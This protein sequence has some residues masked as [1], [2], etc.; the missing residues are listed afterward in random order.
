MA[1]PDKVAI[2]EEIQQKLDGSDAAVLTEYRGLTVGELAELRSALRPA[3]T[4]YKV[5][6]N[7]LARR[8][9]EASGHEELLDLL[10]GPVAFAFVQGDAAVAAK[11]IDDFAGD[12]DALIVKGGLLGDTFLAAV[13]VKALAKLEPRDVILAKIAGAFQA[14]MTKAAGLFSAIPRQM[15]QLTQALVDKRVAEGEEPETDT[16]TEKNDD[17]TESTED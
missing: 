1:R 8:A 7:S 13:D 5:F 2:V 4:E 6:K 9:V 3:A 12:H 15:A 17:D 16:E 11:A 14:P 10:E